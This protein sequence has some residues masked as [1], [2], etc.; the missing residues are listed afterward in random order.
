VGH[1]PSVF[2][3]LWLT[4][5]YFFSLVVTPT[6]TVDGSAASSSSSS[7]APVGA[8]NAAFGNDSNAAAVPRHLSIPA[9]ALTAVG[10][11]IALLL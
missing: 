2:F 3:A 5:V 9:L 11:A 7:V 8:A 10:G 6:F 4:K 1:T